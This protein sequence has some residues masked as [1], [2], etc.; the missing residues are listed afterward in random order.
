MDKTAVPKQRSWARRLRR[1]LIVCVIG[2]S[3]LFIAYTWFV[4]TWSYSKG[5]RAGYVQ[6]FSQRGWIVKTWEGELAMV[7]IPGSM[8]EKFY[9]TV[10]DDSAVAHINATLG[11]RVSLEYEEHVGIPTTLF[12]DTP[13]FVI[14][15]RTLE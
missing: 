15:V 3:V 11:R 7:N 2:S 8:T 12:G 4:L 9:F 13:Y 1:W 10:H 14:G 5:E 6:K